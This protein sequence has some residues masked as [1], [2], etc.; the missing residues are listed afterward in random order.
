M[1]TLPRAL[2]QPYGMHSLTDS[3]FTDGLLCARHDARQTR[4]GT[5]HLILGRKADMAPPVFLE[6]P[7]GEGG[8]V[9]GFCLWMSPLDP[10][11]PLPE[12]G[13]PCPHPGWMWRIQVGE[14]EP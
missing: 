14:A 12:M 3:T 4:A 13:C 5:Y 10:S 6:L 9:T 1:S 8:H 7:G 2:D 11:D